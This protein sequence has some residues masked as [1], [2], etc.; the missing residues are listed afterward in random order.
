M[1]VM[2]MKSALRCLTSRHLRDFL[3]FSLVLCLKNES[4]AKLYWKKTLG[5]GSS[6]QD[7][8]WLSHYSKLEAIAQFLA[9]SLAGRHG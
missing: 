1:E 6:T 7:F 8:T 4:E 9:G 3:Q 5:Q 2:D